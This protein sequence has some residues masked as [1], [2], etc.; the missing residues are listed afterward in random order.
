[1][2]LGLSQTIVSNVERGS[3]SLSVMELRDWLR[4]LGVDFVQFADRLEKSLA[5]DHL[6]PVAPE[7]PV[8]R[9]RT[10]R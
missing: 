5:N 10:P 9:R 1:M 3:R 7:R 8:A 4:A 6:P 2:D